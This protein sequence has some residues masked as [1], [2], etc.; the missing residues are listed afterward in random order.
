MTCL[1]IIERWR[2]LPEETKLRIRW[3]AIP[4]DVAQSMAFAGEP[5]LIETLRALH[6]RIPRPVLSK[7]MKHRHS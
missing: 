3:M 6:A 2:R 1:E 5:V 7:S 4:A